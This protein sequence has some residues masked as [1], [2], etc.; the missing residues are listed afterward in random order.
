MATFWVCPCLTLYQTVIETQFTRKSRDDCKSDE[1]ENSLELMSSD[2]DLP[3][4]IPLVGNWA[5]YRLITQIELVNHSVIYPA[6]ILKHTVIIW[7]VDRFGA[8][9]QSFGIYPKLA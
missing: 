9:R 6:N 1:Q 4:I 2:L 7:L 5:I 3:M 8:W